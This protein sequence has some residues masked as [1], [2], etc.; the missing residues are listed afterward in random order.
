MTQLIGGLSTSHSPQLNTGPEV[1]IQRAE[2]DRSNP[3]FRYEDLLERPDL[4]DLSGLL[5][6][7]A[8]R[9]THA[10][11]QEALER[12]R[13]LYLELEPDVVV[14]I[15][16]DQ[17][18]MF[19]GDVIPAVAVYCGPEVDDIPRPLDKLHPSQVPGEW[20]YHGT[21][22]ATRAVDAELALHLVGALTDAGFEIT[23]IRNQPPG[24]TLGHAFTF[25][26]RRIMVDR[27]VPIVPIMVNTD[28]V[29]SAPRV[30]RCWELGSALRE[31]IESFTSD[32]RV[33]VVG[34][35]GLSHFKLDEALDQAAIDAIRAG[36]VE[37]LSRLPESE[38][39]LGT[40]EIRNWVIAA[41]CLQDQQF[42]LLDYV[43]AYR[44]EAGTGCGMGFATWTPSG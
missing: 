7:A 2:W 6:V 41:G 19:T 14:I 25:V 31:A 1:W 42:H 38:L 24:C 21:E 13:E 34:S 35:G 23:Q 37:A 29:L 15:G 10:A 5:G 16:D 11:C 44:S 18:E 33:L 20:A 17:H 8:F 32:R 28:H 26:Q 12:L 36:D 9:K 30:R 4:P 43:A 3:V 39:I 22:V 27:M 40:S